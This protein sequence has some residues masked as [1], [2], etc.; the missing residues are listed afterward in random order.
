[1]RIKAFN[2][3]KNSNEYSGIGDP[4]IALISGAIRVLAL[5]FSS[6]FSILSPCSSRWIDRFSLILDAFA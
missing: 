2:F 4:L 6:I 5:D 1:L 3:G